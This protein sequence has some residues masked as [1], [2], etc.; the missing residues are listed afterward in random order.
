MKIEN[1]SPLQWQFSQRAEQ[2]QSSAIREIL[3]ITMR[4]EVISFAGGLPSPATFPVEKMR[5]AF[6][7]VLSRQG[8]VALQYGPTDGYAPLREWIAES[9]SIDGAKIV[10]EQVLMVS[11]SQQGLVLLA[12][13]L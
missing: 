6:D 12:K 1:P 11:G 3:K 8:K 13:V 2:L 7:S 10:P 5:A 9:L 4:P